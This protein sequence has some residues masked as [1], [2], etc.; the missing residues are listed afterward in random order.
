MD[1]IRSACIAGQLLAVAINNVVTPDSSITASKH[2]RIV[3]LHIQ[4]PL[5][6]SRYTASQAFPRI[7]ITEVNTVRFDEDELYAFVDAC[8]VRQCC[9]CSNEC[10]CGNDV[11]PV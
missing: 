9:W 5:I 6:P 3:S 2:M 10:D 4:T 8:W 1:S 11:L 7:A